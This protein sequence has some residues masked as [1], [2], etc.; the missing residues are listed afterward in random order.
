[1][2]RNDAFNKST[3]DNIESPGIYRSRRVDENIV[4]DSIFE[5]HRKSIQRR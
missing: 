4:C 5:S 3:I 2:A 1:M